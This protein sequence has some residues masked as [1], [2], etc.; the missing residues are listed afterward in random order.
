M[1]PGVVYVAPPNHH[2]EIHGTRLVLSTAGTERSRPSVDR[3][4]TT[5]AAA[6]GEQVIAVILSGTGFDGAAGARAVKLAGGTVLSQ[7]PA[8]ARFR[9]MPQAL[10]PTTV[11]LVA[12]LERL[13]PL[14]RE[15]VLGQRMPASVD[16]DAA[17]LRFLEQLRDHVG[18]DFTQYKRPTIRRRLHQRM[19]ATHTQTLDAYAVFVEAQ[20]EERQRLINSFLINVTEF[21][22]DPDLFTLLEQ[23]VLPTLLARARQRSEPLRLWSAGCATGEEAYSL[24]LL[25]AEALGDELDRQEVRLFATDIDAEAVAFARQARYPASAVAKVPARLLGRY[26]TREDGHYQLSKRVRAMIVFGQ[27]DLAQGIPFPRIDL[28]LCRNVL[29]YFRPDLQER[30]LALFAAALRDEGYLALGPAEVIS[31]PL[32]KLFTPVKRGYKLYQRVGPPLSAPP[33]GRRIRGTRDEHPQPSPGSAPPLE[34]VPSLLLEPLLPS[35]AHEVL[36]AV[37]LGLVIVDRHYD[38]QFLNRAARPLLALRDLALGEDLIHCL[39]DPLAH[40]LRD[41]IDQALQMPLSSRSMPK[42]RWPMS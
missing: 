29:I 6:Y 9:G 17:L 8:T 41:L 2:V 5:A 15:L 36:Q 31:A 25:V 33:A 16:E 40:E 23:T 19:L 34:G 38:V 27:H 1:E 14:L 13:G 39:Q 21:F 35:L 26:F 32:T 20:P 24:A 18:L 3:L 37:P 4:L 12:D 10:A 22:R 42:S 11:D 30:A 7:N 28:V